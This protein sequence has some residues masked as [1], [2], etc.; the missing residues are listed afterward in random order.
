MWLLEV[1]PPALPSVPSG[2]QSTNRA[3]CFTSHIPQHV[4]P[5][6][7]SL[8]P[9]LLTGIHMWILTGSAGNCMCKDRSS[10]G[11]GLCWAPRSRTA[12][13]EPTNTYTPLELEA[14]RSCSNP[15]VR[16]WSGIIIFAVPA[17][18]APG[19]VYWARLPGDFLWERE[20]EG[21][22]QLFIFLWTL[23]RKHPPSNRDRKKCCYVRFTYPNSREPQHRSKCAFPWYWVTWPAW[24][25]TSLW[26]FVHP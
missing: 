21:W 19:W 12:S 22:G 9:L 7:P 6:S 10:A 8:P 23:N 16:A 13:C 20:K 2:S 24:R 17:L 18:T 1:F 4:Q 5:A 25:A 11:E 15:S 14:G 26:N 3:S